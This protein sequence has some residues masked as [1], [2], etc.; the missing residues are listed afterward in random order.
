MTLSTL[1]AT[2]DRIELARTRR[3]LEDT[4]VAA[5]PG[6]TLEH[7]VADA[8]STDRWTAAVRSADGRRLTL[9]LDRSLQ[10]V[11]VAAAPAMARAA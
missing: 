6:A 5:I 2:A 7:L 1:P 10:T 4:A 3:M 9:R 11:E 8:G